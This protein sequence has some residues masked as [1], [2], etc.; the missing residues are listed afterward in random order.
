MVMG[1][2][3]VEVVLDGISVSADD[4][5]ECRCGYGLTAVRLLVQ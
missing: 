3:A 2:V 1:N 4:G 5:G